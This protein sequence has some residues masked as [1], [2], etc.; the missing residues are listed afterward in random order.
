MPKNLELAYII[1][2]H[3]NAVLEHPIMRC[4]KPFLRLTQT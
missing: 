1:I 3:R 4:N 2:I